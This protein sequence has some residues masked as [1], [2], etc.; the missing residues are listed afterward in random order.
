MRI[1]VVED[2]A[3][4]AKLMLKYMEQLGECDWVADGHEAL[5]AIRQSYRENYPFDLICLDI[6]MP[7]LDGYA[8]LTEIRNVEREEGLQIG[9]GTKILMVSG[10]EDE[11]SIL[12][13]FMKLCD[14]YLIKPVDEKQLLNKLEDIELLSP[15]KL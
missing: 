4:A 7:G 1:L 14:G 10:L 9:E 3:V 5:R 2:D 6:M 12:K 13:S 11:G 15:R 8:T